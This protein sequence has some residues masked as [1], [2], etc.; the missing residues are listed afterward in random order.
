M[1]YSDVYNIISNIDI[2]MNDN[3]KF[4]EYIFDLEDY[5]IKLKEEEDVAV[6]KEM[7]RYYMFL[8]YLYIIKRR[9]VY[10]INIPENIS[11]PLFYLANKLDRTPYINTDYILSND[12]FKHILSEEFISTQNMINLKIKLL[13]ETT[14]IKEK[15]SLLKNI[16]IER[17]IIKQNEY[18]YIK[19][20]LIYENNDIVHHTINLINI[21][22]EL[23]CKEKNVLNI[24]LLNELYNFQVIN[25]K[26][27]ITYFIQYDVHDKLCI[28]TQLKNITNTLE[29]LCILLINCEMNSEINTIIDSYYKKVYIL[30]KQLIE[31][32]NNSIN[33]IVRW[34]NL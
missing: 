7:Y 9:K 31:L 29:R 13:N 32:H 2:I 6:L 16:N 34:Q 3:N 30:D 14:N 23:N 12:I 28:A 10:K 15:I 4:E 25:L 8:S 20:C 22:M 19:K 21:N 24:I 11:N 26:H 27:S 18:V 1:S 17:S 5:I 33:N